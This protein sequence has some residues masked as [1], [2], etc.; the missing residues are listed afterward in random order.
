MSYLRT[1]DP[2]LRHAVLTELAA[3]NYQVDEGHESQVRELILHEARSCHWRLLAIQ[4]L[5]ADREM[6]LL[7]DALY[8]DLHSC[9]ERILLLVA[10]LFPTTVILDAKEKLLGGYTDMKAN[11]LEVIDNLVDRDLN[12]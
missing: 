1:T 8:R 2:L 7:I 12:Y 5:K 4:E 10:L 9:K 11:G 3:S 6:S